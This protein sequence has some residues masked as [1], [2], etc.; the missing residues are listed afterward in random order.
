MAVGLAP[1]DPYW[2]VHRP[3]IQT[4]LVTFEG[5]AERAQTVLNGLEALAGLARPDDLVF[6]HD[7]AR[8]CVRAED[9][10]R[11]WRAA[12]D[13]EDGALLARPVADTVKREGAGGVSLATVDRRGLWLAQTPQ[14]FRFARLKDALFEAMSAHALVT[15]EASAIE[16]VG[17]TPVLVA[18]SADNLKITVPQDLVL[19]EMYLAQQGL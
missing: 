19:A 15:D 4:P 3:H 17:G 12:C 6:V 16:R 10:A 13:T 5:G 8:P 9:L 2:D 7:A 1:G 11:L 18:G 14:V